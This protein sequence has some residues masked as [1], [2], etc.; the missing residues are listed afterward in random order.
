MFVYFPLCYGPCYNIAAVCVWERAWKKCLKCCCFSLF[1]VTR[2]R[3]PKQFRFVLFPSSKCRQIY[4]IL[5]I[6]YFHLVVLFL[7]LDFA[8]RAAG[9]PFLPI[10]WFKII[11]WKQALV[12][13]VCFGTRLSLH[14]SLLLRFGSLI[15]TTISNILQLS[16]KTRVKIYIY[17]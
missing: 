8:D 14:V 5:K 2:K 3:E 17:I 4:S 11:I 13:L 6:M 9:V 10:H 16:R 1:L 12:T 7:A 15:Q